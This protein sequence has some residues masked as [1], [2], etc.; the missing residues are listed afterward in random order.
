MATGSD[1][2]AHNSPLAVCEKCGHQGSP[3]EMVEH[4]IVP[5]A[6]GGSD[7]ADNL[8]MLCDHCARYVPDEYLDPEEYEPVFED[9]IATDTRPEVDFAYFGVIATEKL[10][11]AYCDAAGGISGELDADKLIESIDPIVNTVQSL[12][13]TEDE[14][15]PA[16]YWILYARFAEYG[17]VT[18]ADP[19]TEKYIDGDLTN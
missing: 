4:H 9:Y 8:A 15:S 2:T 1:T 16:F 11:T 12:P 17:R 6:V 3:E 7:E 19:L 10:A 18:E 5:L 13:A 14:H